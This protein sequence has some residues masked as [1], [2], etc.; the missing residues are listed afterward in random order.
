VEN[1]NNSHTNWP[2]LY[3][4]LNLQ[5]TQHALFVVDHLNSIDSDTLNNYNYVYLLSGEGNTVRFRHL[6]RPGVSFFDSIV[7]DQYPDT[8]PW[9]FHFNQVNWVNRQLNLLSQLIPTQHKITT[10]LFD[11]LLGLQKSH[12]DYA[13]N[14]INSCKWLEQKTFM[15]YYGVDHDFVPGYH[16]KMSPIDIKWSSEN[17]TVN[18]VATWR[19]QVLPVD[20]YN[21]TF[22]TLVCETDAETKTHSFFTEKIAKPMLAR[23]PFVVLANQY[24]LRRLRQ[25]GFKTFDGVVDESYDTTADHVTRWSMALEQMKLLTD[26]D[27]NKIYAGVADTL[28]HNQHLIQ[29]DWQHKL[30]QQILN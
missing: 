11:V 30:T 18:N 21:Q 16:S 20:I 15:T 14:W 22:Y 26:Q 19:S 27:P 4:Q 7:S 13:Y 6:A 24:Y 23:R 1:Q 17:I 5:T 10:K 25:L 3:T 28:D 29:S 8:R 12:R 2:E 9:M